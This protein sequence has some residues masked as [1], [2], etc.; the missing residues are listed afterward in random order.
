M[1]VGRYSSP[2]IEKINERIHIDGLPISDEML[3]NSLSNVLDER[4]LAISDGT[5]GAQATWFDVMT[6]AAF[7]AFAQI[8]ITWGVI[9]VGLGG[10]LD[11][12]NIVKSDIAVIT[13]IGLEHTEVLGKTVEAIALEK[14]GIIK[15]DKLLVTPLNPNSPAGSVV[16]GAAKLRNAEIMHVKI[17]ENSS[18]S[19]VNIE[20][21]RRVLDAVNILNLYNKVTFSSIGG[22]LLTAQII[23]NASLPGRQERFYISGND[24]ATVTTVLDGA[25]VDFALEGVLS[26]LRSDHDLQTAPIVLVAF[27]KDKNA[28]AMLNTLRK[29]AAKVIFVPLGHNRPSWDTDELER[30]ARS[31]GISAE[32][33]PS[34]IAG[35]KRCLKLAQGRWILVTGSLHLVGAI[36]PFLVDF[37]D[38]VF[39]K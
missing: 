21:A 12:T 32:S 9:E 6:A 16:F 3:A 2:H 20:T 4:D 36:R 25:H 22:H 27:G 38:S 30:I 28:L 34:P 24:N 35:F 18:I 37:D 29:S 14:A 15:P 31:L 13:N 23:K 19:E 1:W 39:L 33:A 10:R 11:S 17:P 26:E 7:H 8:G 5:E